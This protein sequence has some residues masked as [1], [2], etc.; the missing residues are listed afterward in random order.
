MRTPPQA[1]GPAGAID[2]LL[3]SHDRL[4][5]AVSGGLDS[6]CLLALVAERL[7]GRRD[8]CVA[9][10]DHG[11]GPRATEAA[12]FVV[13]RA[14]AAGL[15][16][17][18]GRAGSVASTEA[19]W[20]E[21]RWRFLRERAAAHDAVVVT[22]HSADDQLETVVM[23]ILRGTGARGLAGLLANTPGVA[24]PFLETRRS[25]LAELA[26]D[27]ELAWVEDPSNA[28]RRFFRNRVR[29]DLLPALVA[30]RPQLPAELMALGRKAAAV[31]ATVD[32]IAT[33]WEVSRTGQT[34]TIDASLL[35]ALDREAR[36][37]AWQSILQRNGI[38]LDRRGLV[39]LSALD[40]RAPTGY[41]LQLSGGIEAMRVR[42]GVVLQPLVRHAS[43]AVTLRD[44]DSTFGP[45]RFTLG[46]PQFAPSGPVVPQAW[47]T[48][49]PA[50]ARLEV[51]EWTPGDRLHGGPGR[52]T[53]RVAR[54]LSDVG[55]P[56]P[57]R[58]GW[59]VV[60]ADGEIIWIPGVRRDFAEPV[61][62]GRPIRRLVCERP[63]S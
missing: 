54:F 4:L 10:F 56:G 25:D 21:A 19:A 39:R 40:Q 51:R 60:V 46:A 49:V 13:E 14:R 3:A 57:A 20:R 41:R 33:R 35:S 22:A 8:V 44:G 45:W 62:S 30:V 18:S 47:E 34:L 2:R 52:L 24:R 55:I 53:R 7:T 29:L 11:S 15:A 1:T 36:A 38:V 59:P 43:A 31:R 9:T 28:D 27:R 37:L 63:S 17:H 61:R 5:L 26:S 32:G 6:M 12:Q 50:A 58:R 16:V 23:R 48:W 42:E